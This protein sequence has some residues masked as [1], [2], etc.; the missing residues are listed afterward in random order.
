LLELLVFFGILIS[1]W[2]V[3][4]F[5]YW[6]VYLLDIPLPASLSAFFYKVWLVKDFIRGFLIALLVCSLILSF[7]IRRIPPREMGIR[8]D[9]ILI[10]GRE[11]LVLILIVLLAASALL[12]IFRGNFSIQNYFNRQQETHRELLSD[13]GLGIISGIAQQFLLQCFFL[14]RTLKIFRNPAIAILFSSAIFST[15]HTPNIILMI[16]TFIF[17]SMC[18]VLF[19]RNRNIITIGITHG[20]AQQI[21]RIFFASVFVSGSYYSGRGYYEYNL[22]I[23]PPRAY[24]EYLAELK[25]DGKLPVTT[26]GASGGVILVP[27]SVTNKSTK[28][29]SSTDESNLVFASYHFIDEDGQLIS[30]DEPLTPLSKPIAPGET[31]IVDLVVTAPSKKGDYTAE[32]DIVRPPPPGSK[33][34]IWFKRRGSKTLLIPITV[35]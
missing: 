11:C 21:L 23:G 31:E 17:G 27:V 29:W 12:L 35:P 10:S 5:W 33:V 32:V 13:L 14:Q 7:Y 22:R 9:N 2:W 6:G 8:T 30:K 1:Y 4:S 3:A 24:P 19:L 34:T 26:T 15:L 18:S 28:L 16:V 20:I 25:Y